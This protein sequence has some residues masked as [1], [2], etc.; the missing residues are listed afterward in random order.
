MYN[1]FA[2]VYDKMQYDVKYSFWSDQINLKLQQYLPQTHKVLELACGTGSLSR[3][4]YQKGYVMEGVDIS[5]DMLTIAKER[6]LEAHMNIPFFCQDITELDLNRQYDSAVLMCDGLN[7]VLE[8]DLV[9]EVLKRVKQHLTPSGLFIFDLSSHYKLSQVIGNET[10]AET[11]E[12]S[13]YIWE[14][15]FDEENE[16]L[17][18]DLTLFIEA[19]GRYERYEEYHTQRA[20]TLESIQTVIAQEYDC[21]E[22]LDGDTFGPLHDKS[23]RWCFICRIK[24]SIKET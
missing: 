13:A 7:Y 14:N 3:H 20:Y 8:L 24:E 16:L 4:L 18:F 17:E 12:D 19:D 6:A 5:E 1:A 22:I 15:T 10:F 2:V 11:F 9:T 21:L 23:E